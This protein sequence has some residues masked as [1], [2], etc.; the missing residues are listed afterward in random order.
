MWRA[1]SIAYLTCPCAMLTFGGC[2]KPGTPSTSLPEAPELKVPVNER[3]E[4]LLNDAEIL[5]RRETRRF[6]ELSAHAG[7]GLAQAKHAITVM[8]SGRI[9]EAP[10][11]AIASFAGTDASGEPYICLWALL[12]AR[13]AGYLWIQVYDESGATRAFRIGI[14]QN[15][16]YTEMVRLFSLR[17]RPTD[18]QTILASVSGTMEAPVT[19]QMDDV[20]PLPVRQDAMQ[21][22]VA[23]QDRSGRVSNYVQVSHYDATRTQS[24]P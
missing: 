15:H 1:L 3:Q 10:P 16:K 7:P 18:W 2:G 8:R 5:L 17:T 24:S 6:L 22:A 4:R 23:V 21:C 14:A 11:V 20:V 9:D 12:P 19:S 13:E